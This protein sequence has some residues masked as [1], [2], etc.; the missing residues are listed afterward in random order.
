MSGGF[1]LS[2]Q[3]VEEKLNY[4]NSQIGSTFKLDKRNTENP[5]V[6]EYGVFCNGRLFKAGSLSNIDSY[7]DGIY[8]GVGL[9]KSNSSGH[10]SNDNP[11]PSSVP[12][13][14]GGYKETPIKSFFKSRQNRDHWNK[15]SIVGKKKAV[16]PEWSDN[17]I[18]YNIEVIEYAETY[19]VFSAKF[20]WMAPNQTMPGNVYWYSGLTLDLTP[21]M[22]LDE[23]AYEITKICDR[24][25]V[26][27][28]M[29]T[30]PNRFA[31]RYILT[32][33]PDM[34]DALG[35]YEGAVTTHSYAKIIS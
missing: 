30:A 22:T 7:I 20:T 19:M 16:D 23:M 4:L 13:S 14:S 29:L 10:H 18:R 11:H 27:E 31:S 8:V 28:A 6:V 35:F 26:K 32:V 5:S 17:G 21:S 33:T 25:Y 15:F 1:K 12:L 3:S 34:P 2:A 24:E 9:P